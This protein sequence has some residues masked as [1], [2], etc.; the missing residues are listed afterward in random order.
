MAQ[1]AFV[2][3]SRD[4]ELFL[5]SFRHNES[6]YECVKGLTIDQFEMAIPLAV[7][8]MTQLNKSVNT[9]E[10]KEM[11]NTEVK[12][13]TDEFEI[14]KAAL[15]EKMSLAL[16]K[17]ENETKSIVESLEQ[18]IKLTL[19]KKDRETKTLIDSL[20]DSEES[21]LRD[22][23][24]LREQYDSMKARIEDAT[25]FSLEQQEKQHGVELQRIRETLEAQARERVEDSHREHKEN[26]E[27]LRKLYEEQAAKDRKELEKNLGS[28]TKGA[29][30]EKECADLIA[31]YTDWAKVQDVSKSSHST[32]MRCRIRNCSTLFEIKKYSEDIPS[33]EVVKFERDMEE[34][35]D[36]PLGVFISMHTNI[37]GKKSGNFITCSWSAK[38]QL[39]I[40]V[41]SFYEHSPQDILEFVDM[42]ADFAWRIFKAARD[43][44]E[45]SEIITQIQGRI[46]QAKIFIEKDIK[47]LSDLVV[48][49]NHNKKFLIDSITKQNAD[50]VGDIQQS[51]GSLQ[52]LLEVLL[53]K[54]EADADANA[55]VN[56]NADMSAST[57]K[58]E[59]AAFT[60][61][62]IQ[63]TPKKKTAP[64]K[65]AVA[66]SSNIV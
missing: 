52:N 14:Q 44:P 45:E 21:V 35:Q 16:L 42:C 30:G 57:M 24:R 3:E 32:D 50:C 27:L 6:L 38:S 29:K 54:C 58:V 62:N 9:L 7:S 33:K 47:R 11:I 17:K 63:E 8:A 20:K 41:N 59:E 5:T 26:I 56:A 48:K 4:G 46:E 39:L 36:C 55:D 13:K 31:L 51:K 43:I 34:N 49:M 61:A 23:V 19:Q 28:S 22:N 25:R 40:F 66:P 65:K 1:R 18:S 37:V 64:R 10:W 15:E 60:V 2:S 53:G 12:K